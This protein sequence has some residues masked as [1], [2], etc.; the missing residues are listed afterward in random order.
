MTNLYHGSSSLFHHFKLKTATHGSDLGF[1]VYLTNDKKRANLY[2]SPYLYEVSFDTSLGKVSSNQTTL[3]VGV[4]TSL[5][6]DISRH[7]MQSDGYPYLLSDWGEPT[8]DTTIDQGNHL[9]ALAIAHQLVGGA[10]DDLDI[11]ND[12]YHQ[13]GGSPSSAFLLASLLS[14]NNIHYATRPFQGSLEYVVFN[15]NDIK[16]NAVNKLK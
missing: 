12:L 11:I 1:G 15:P 2:A 6:E 4:V 7:Q 14:L 13:I 9:I 3:S 10:L 5:I 16:I 8:S